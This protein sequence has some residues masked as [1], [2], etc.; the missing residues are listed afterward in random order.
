[1]I[2]EAGGRDWRLLAACALVDPETF[3]PVDIADD[4]PAVARAKRVCA[5]CPVRVECL[6]D[7]MAGE[8]PA[9]RWGVTAGLT[10]TERAGLFASRRVTAAR[11]GA[12]AA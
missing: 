7:V 9:R 12:V 1:M 5:G 6:V 10:P 3:Y 11:C 2:G 4:A 8:D